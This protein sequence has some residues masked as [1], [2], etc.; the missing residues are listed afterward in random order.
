MTFDD[1]VSRLEKVKDNYDLVIDG[2]SG[3]GILDSYPTFVFT[4]KKSNFDVRSFRNLWDDFLLAKNRVNWLIK[5]T[6]E[7]GFVKPDGT[8]LDTVDFTFPSD[9]DDM[10]V[11]G[12][13]S[14][15][16]TKMETVLDQLL[17]ILIDNN[18]ISS[19]VASDG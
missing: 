12:F 2:L 6:N 5:L 9:I 11:T 18:I 19:K 15:Q 1:L 10:K 13:Y 14:F 7:N 8:D 3:I 17:H 16:L 4:Y